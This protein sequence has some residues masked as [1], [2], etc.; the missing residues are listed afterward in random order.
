MI[1]KSTLKD[2]ERVVRIV[3][4][5][6]LITAGTSK[7]FSH[8]GF[9]D[10]YLTLFQGEHLRIK[11]PPALI[12]F[13]LQLVPFIEISLGLSL[14]SNKYKQLAI[15]GWFGFMLSLLVGHYILQEWSSVNDILDYFFLGILC[16][17][18]PNHRS[19]FK[20]DAVDH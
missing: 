17:A 15:Y 3:M 20:R 14:F 1:E 18:L 13:Y 7:F 6:I 2:I 5:T 8:G 9:A 11:M 4:I 16:F 12:N 19:W 10:Y